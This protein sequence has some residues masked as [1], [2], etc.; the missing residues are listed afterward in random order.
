MNY[1]PVIFEKWPAKIKTDLLR[2]SVKKD[3]KD[4]NSPL[5]RKLTQMEALL[6]AGEHMLSCVEEPHE[7]GHCGNTVVWSSRCF[8][9][10]DHCQMFNL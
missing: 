3:K 7:H 2:Q 9:C 4:H 5:T 8:E 6:D 10:D 1:S